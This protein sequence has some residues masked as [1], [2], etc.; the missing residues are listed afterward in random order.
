MFREIL[1]VIWILQAVLAVVFVMAGSMKLSQPREKLAVRMG[2]V[3]HFSA[4]AVKVIGL[5]EVLAAAGL[6]LPSLS[7]VL[8]WL[9]P[10]RPGWSW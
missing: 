10:P 2:W 6:I 3:A 7:G 1:L 8:R 5:L 4:P 9:T